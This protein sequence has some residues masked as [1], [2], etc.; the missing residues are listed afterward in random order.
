[1]KIFLD[2]NFKCHLSDDG[3]MSAVETDY[4]DGKC[5]KYVEGF[6]LVPFGSTWVREDGMEFHGEMIA[7]WRP[8]EELADAQAAWE[9]EELERLRAEMMANEAAYQEGV[10]SA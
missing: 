6:R 3:T 2:S 10:A 8:Y 4:F 7:P 9:H 1:M 5:K